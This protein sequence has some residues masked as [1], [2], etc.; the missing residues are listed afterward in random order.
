MRFQENPGDNDE[1]V[2]LKKITDDA[3]VPPDIPRVRHPDKTPTNP[4]FRTK[5]RH[6]DP[7][8]LLDDI[9]SRTTPRSDRPVHGEPAAIHGAAWFIVGAV[10]GALV[11]LTGLL[12]GHAI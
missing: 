10:F 9:R 3:A 12:V 4:Q 2:V 7:D 6:D 1:T 11:M 5:P 8:G